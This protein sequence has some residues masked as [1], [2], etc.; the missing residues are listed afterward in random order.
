MDIGSVNMKWEV[1]DSRLIHSSNTFSNYFYVNNFLFS[2]PNKSYFSNFK[3][4]DNG[5][6][7]V[8]PSDIMYMEIPIPS[9]NIRQDSQNYFYSPP[10]SFKCFTAENNVN[11]IKCVN[12]S[13]ISRNY[14]HENIEDNER[15]VH[16]DNNFGLKLANRIDE[17]DLID[18]NLEEAEIKGWWHF[19]NSH[20]SKIIITDR[21]KFCYYFSINLICQ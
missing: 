18:I 9:V 13:G 14:D 4:A 1:G 16:Y 21:L 10:R 6:D 19:R 12:S 11:Q 7:K 8:L 20:T 17:E 15:N 5:T 2:N 3:F